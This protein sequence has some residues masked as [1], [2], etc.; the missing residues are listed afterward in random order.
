MSDAPD[1]PTLNF[2][3][4]E[5]GP[6]PR[7]GCNGLMQRHLVL[8]RQTQAGVRTL[9]GAAD[10]LSLAGY[11]LASRWQALLRFWLS[12]LVT[13]AALV[14]FLEILGPPERDDA[15]PLPDAA[16]ALKLAPAALPLPSAN[17]LVDAERLPA[18]SAPMRPEPNQ[19]APPGLPSPGGAAQ[20]DA[21]RPRVILVL[22]PARPDG[23]GTIASRL[24]AQSGLAPDQVNIGPVAEARSEAV[25]RF[26]STGDHPLA[27][28]L[29]REL[30]RMN[31][32]WRIENFAAR[33]WAWKDQAVEVFL[34]DK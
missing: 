7:R 10:A 9:P 28:R 17:R 30:T 18:A 32:P 31:V 4:P 15:E 3:V 16:Q 13:A 5:Q 29:G 22:H 23:V 27:R 20:P 34:P 8:G 12:V 1:G 26:Y 24:A 33:S 14:L 11:R 21:P 2:A 25:I 6:P 19:S